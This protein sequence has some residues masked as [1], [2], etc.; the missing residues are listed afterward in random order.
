M[1]EFN[2]NSNMVFSNKIEIDSQVLVRLVDQEKEEVLHVLLKI[3]FYN[4]K[5]SLCENTKSIF[6]EMQSLIPY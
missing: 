4:D 3:I 6:M 2:W 5:P 1:A